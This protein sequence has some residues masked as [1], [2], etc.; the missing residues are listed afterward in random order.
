MNQDK[1]LRGSITKSLLAI[2]VPVIFANILQTVYQ[3]IDT[4]WVGRLGTEAVAAVS[5]S[6]PLLFFLMSLAMGLVMAAS[7]LVAQYNGKEDKENVSFTVGQSLSLVILIAVIISIIGY[8]SSH[9][10]LS[11]LTKDVLVLPQ[12]TS[13]LQISFLGIMAMFIYTLF[14]SSLRGVGEVKVPLI[15]ISITVVIN[16]FLDP[17]LMFGW[18]FIPAMGV[19]GVALATLITEY[20]SAIIAIVLLIRGTYG[21]KLRLNDLKLKLSWVKKLFKL[22]LPSSF[23]MGSR[24][25]GMVLMTFVASM[26]GTLTI[27]SFGIGMKVFMFVI[28][29][30]V[31][32]SIATSAIVGN[33]LGARQYERA[34]RIVKTGMKVSF[35][36]LAILGVLLFIFAKPISAFFVPNEPL[37]V[38]ESARF[39]QIMALTFGFIGMQMVIFGT[40]KAAGKTTTAMLLALFNTVMLFVISY[41]LSTTAGMQQTGIWI[42]YPISNVI[43]AGIAYYFYRKKDW[44]KKELV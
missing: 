29:P 38:M 39:I 22:G 26:F 7:I 1:M 25:F 32:F 2:A 15:I 6:F 16:F 28:I 20:L 3:L 31:G 13:Y 17:V 44:L 33:N 43:S 5:L 9:Y 41:V 35:L 14:Q 12:A 21:I 27:A 30:G 36:T 40:L 37:L 24:S 42:A 4:F 19:S 34:E 11:F 8:F 23:E 18:R 10:L